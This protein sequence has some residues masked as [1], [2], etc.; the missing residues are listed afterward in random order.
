[1]E[2]RK[3]RRIGSSIRAEKKCTNTHTVKRAPFK[4]RARFLCGGNT[5]DHVTDTGR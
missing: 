2:M 5:C 3:F 4:N 1:M